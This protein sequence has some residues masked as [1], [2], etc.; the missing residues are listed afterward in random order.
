MTSFYGRSRRLLPSLICR[1]SILSCLIIFFVHNAKTSRML[2]TSYLAQP[3]CRRIRLLTLT[4]DSPQ[5]PSASH[6]RQLQGTSTL[7]ISLIR[8]L[9][10]SGGGVSRALTSFSPKGDGN[11]YLPTLHH[12]CTITS[13]Q[14]SGYRQSQGLRSFISTV[15][16]QTPIPSVVKAVAM[17]FTECMGPMGLHSS[18]ATGLPERARHWGF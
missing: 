13:M 11:I 14:E 2:I 4:C 18:S 8:H 3:R 5:I 15:H 9:A 10:D 1:S 16:I 17:G 6:P 7:H 12:T